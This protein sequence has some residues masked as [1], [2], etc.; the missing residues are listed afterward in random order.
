MDQD[1]GS[2]LSFKVYRVDI[3]TLSLS[4]DLHHT[5]HPFGQRRDADASRIYLAET[6]DAGRGLTLGQS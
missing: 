2:F 3:E 4:G 5:R 1:F 6:V